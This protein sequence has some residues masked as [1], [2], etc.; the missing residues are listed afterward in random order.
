MPSRLDL[1]PDLIEVA[2][3]RRCDAQNVVPDIAAVKRDRIVVDANIAV[4]GL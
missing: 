2:L 4:E 1:V 3:A